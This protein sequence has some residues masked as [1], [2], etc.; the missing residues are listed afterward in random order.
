MDYVHDNST[1][2]SSTV[3]KVLRMPA[4]NLRVQLEQSV[5]ELGA[6]REET[7]KVRKESEVALKYFS[8]LVRNSGQQRG[9]VNAVDLDA[10]PPGATAGMH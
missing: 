8:N 9:Q 6:R 3:R 4:D 2:I 1:R 7:L 10:P 5:K